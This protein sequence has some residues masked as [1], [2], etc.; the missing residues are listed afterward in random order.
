MLQREGLC[1]QKLGCAGKGK[2]VLKRAAAGVALLQQGRLKSPKGS[3]WSLQA[4]SSA[5]DRKDQC[6]QTP[7]H[8]TH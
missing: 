1:C 4:T 7:I 5:A 8:R 2:G 3:S 6:K